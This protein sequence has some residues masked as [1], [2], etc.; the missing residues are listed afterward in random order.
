MIVKQTVI[1]GIDLLKIVMGASVTSTII[2]I[3]PQ[4]TSTH[5]SQT[6]VRKIGHTVLADFQS[7]TTG[8]SKIKEVFLIRI[9]IVTG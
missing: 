9:A 2:D 3:P 4:K 5:W 6:I 8:Y 7:Y 1:F